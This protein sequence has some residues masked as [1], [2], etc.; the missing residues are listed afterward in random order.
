MWLEHS[1]DP[2]VQGD[3]SAWFGTAPSVPAACDASELLGPDGCA[4]NGF[5]NFDTIEFW[6]TPESDCFGDAEEGACVPYSDW[7]TAYQEM[8]AG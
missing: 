8:L 2:K 5:D 4:T 6:K 1:L 3:V 7:V